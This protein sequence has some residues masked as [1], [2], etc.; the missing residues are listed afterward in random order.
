MA[1][2]DKLK[3]KKGKQVLL[4]S[5]MIL[6]VFISFFIGTMVGNKGS[7]HDDH[8]HSPEQS[9]GEA[10]VWT[11]SMHPSVQLPKFGQCPICFMDLIPLEPANGDNDPDSPRLS[12]S[13]NAKKLAGIMTLPVVRKGVASEIRMTGKVGLDQSR[14][15]K[16]TSRISG[17]IDRLFVQYT[18]IKVKNGDHLAEIYSPELLSLQRELL[19]AARAVK[20]LGPTASDMVRT[21]AKKTLEAAKEKLRLLGFKE[22]ELQKILIRGKTSD[23]MTIRSTQQGFVLE[24]LID[25]GQYV[26]IGTPLF[27]IVDL[28]KVWVKLDAYESDLSWLRLRQKITFTVEAYPGKKFKGTISFI[29]PF[30]NP[31]TRT[32]MVRLIAD[33]SSGMLKPDMFVKAE[34]KVNYIT[35]GYSRTHPL[36]IPASSILFTGER[37]VVYVED[38]EAVKP[39]FEGKEVVLGP[40]AGD[41]YIVNSGLEEGEMVVVN[42]AFKIDGELQIRAK[43]SMMNPKK[44]KKKIEFIAERKVGRLKDPITKKARYYLEHILIDYLKMSDE[45]AADNFEKSVEIMKT[46][47]RKLNTMKIPEVKQYSQIVESVNVIKKRLSKLQYVKTIDEAR[48]IF[49][50]I[51]A[52]VI[53]LEKRYGHNF[54]GD[55]HLTFCPMAFDDKGAYWL[56]Q[57][58]VVNNP[59]FG[60]Q[61]LKCGVI[62]ETFKPKI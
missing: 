17:R 7:S 3:G 11:C 51:S 57:K 52:Y 61:M 22:T 40:K 18:G 44:E 25:E 24:K 49:E 45:L 4:I 33:N 37:A 27:Q 56:Q 8:D 26:K 58:D 5:S 20:G 32:V 62:K 19:E 59:Y 23:H 60:S 43:P 31:K 9:A 35:S 39:T 42:G 1:K 12:M 55:V 36:I 6:L 16:I 46:M 34:V 30:V 10:T 14:I 53:L 47:K 21:S 54:K 28:N 15:E 48:R 38:T 50:D 29:D 2:E 41:Y 13:E